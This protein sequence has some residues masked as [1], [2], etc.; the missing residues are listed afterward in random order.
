MPVVATGV[1]CWANLCNEK[2]YVG[3]AAKGLAGR[4]KTHVEKLRCGR[5]PNRYLQSAWLKYGESA[6]RFIVLERCPPE[7]CIP[8]EQ[9]FIDLFRAADREYGYNL[10]PTA[11]SPLGVKHSEETCR[12]ISERMRGTKQ[13]SDHIRKR[14]EGWKAKVM[15]PEGLKRWSEARC[16]KKRTEETRRKISESRKGKPLSELNREGLREAW[17]KRK[18]QLSP[19]VITEVL[20]LLGTGLSQQKIADRLDIPQATVCNINRGTYRGLR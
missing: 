18:P 1:Y 12:K 19:E 17:K 7:S 10:S 3:S 14:V 4:R 16:G 5:H 11:G 15:T 8:R 2:L 6:F 20:L 13:S 9:F